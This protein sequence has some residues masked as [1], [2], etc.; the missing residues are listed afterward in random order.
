MEV[1]DNGG[2]GNGGDP[3]NPGP[4]NRNPSPGRLS[5]VR[6]Y[7]HATSVGDGGSVTSV[8][9]L[10]FNVVLRSLMSRYLR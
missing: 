1:G 5:P 9:M 8:W 4:S 10:R 2:G 7:D 6:G 3:D